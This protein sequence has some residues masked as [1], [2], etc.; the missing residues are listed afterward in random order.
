ML[1]FKR[2]VFINILSICSDVDEMRN[3]LINKN[4]EPDIVVNS[5]RSEE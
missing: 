3:D 2:F 5:E 4:L 1:S